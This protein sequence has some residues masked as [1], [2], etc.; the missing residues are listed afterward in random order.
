MFLKRNSN[1]DLGSNEMGLQFLQ[2]YK[3]A[4]CL[5]SIVL[6]EV[7]RAMVEHAV[8][9]EAVIG[10][11]DDLLKQSAVSVGM[12]E[13]SVRRVNEME[14]ETV[15]DIL[16][17][18]YG[19]VPNFAPLDKL[20]KDYNKLRDDSERKLRSLEKEKRKA[21]QKALKAE[22]EKRKEENTRTILNSNKNHPF[23]SHLI[24]YQK[25]IHPLSFVIRSPPPSFLYR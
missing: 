11:I 24:F 3:N 14:I 22:E 21:E 7:D 10:N 4:K 19:E 5:Y 2:N 16:I 20:R 6:V 12:D 23:F 9:N 15:E 25:H 13:E 17:R 8:G 1:V 18:M